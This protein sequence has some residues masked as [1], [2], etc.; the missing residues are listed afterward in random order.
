MNAVGTAD[1]INKKYPH[2][3]EFEFK[4]D[5]KLNRIILKPQGCTL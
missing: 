4:F 3:A 5:L 2:F 1:C